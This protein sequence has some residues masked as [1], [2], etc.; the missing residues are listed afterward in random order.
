LSELPDKQRVPIEHTKLQG[1]SIAEAAQ[2]TGQ[3]EA[4]VKVNIH[5]G[6]K[7][8]AQKFGVTP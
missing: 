4:A 7:A 2:L 8:L 5:R 1:L 6:L 3:S